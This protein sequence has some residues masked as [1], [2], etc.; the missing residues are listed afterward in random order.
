MGYLLEGPF[1]LSFQGFNISSFQGL[2]LGFSQVVN[3]SFPFQPLGLG[4]NVNASLSVFKFGVRPQIN[5][6]L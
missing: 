6:R 1:S 3:L 5:S 4:L 2:G